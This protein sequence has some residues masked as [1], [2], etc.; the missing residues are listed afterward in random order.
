MIAMLSPIFQTTGS[1]DEHGIRSPGP[2]RQLKL[3]LGYYYVEKHFWFHWDRM[4]RMIVSHWYPGAFSVSGGRS[5]HWVDRGSDHWVEIQRDGDG[6]SFR[7]R[8]RIESG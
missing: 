6:G 7:Q 3:S 5:F 2:V 4:D 1:S 8:A